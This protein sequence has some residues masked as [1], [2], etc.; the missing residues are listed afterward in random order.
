MS[1]TPRKA[2]FRMRLSAKEKEMV[3]NLRNNPL[4]HEE[5]SEL[6]RECLAKG[7]NI[8]TVKQV[9]YKDKHISINTNEKNHISYSDVREDMITAMEGYSPSYPKIKR[10]KKGKHLL[11]ID[12]ADLHI[13]KYSDPALT[14][15]EYNSDIAVKRALE[16]TKGLIQKASG[17]NID[18]ILFIIGNDVLNTDTI[19]KTTTKGTP[20]D[21][22]LHWFK[23]F[24]L[25]RE[26]YV[27][28][29]EMCMQVADVD[30]IH[31]PSNH[32]VMSGSFLADALA[33]WFR[34]SK[35]VEFFISPSYRKYYQYG[36]NMMEFEHGDK[37]K[38]QNLPLIMAQEQPV[39]W[40][41]TKYRYGYLHHVHHSD[42]TQF[43]SGKDYI[44]VNVTYLKSPSSADLWHSDQGYISTL[45][46]EGFVH[47]YEYGRVAH[48]T[49][50]F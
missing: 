32:D 6:E 13:N 24:Q 45:A 7:I 48:L 37:G 46:V 2:P 49:H 18:K 4:T 21:T 15:D 5:Q 30:V 1:D 29:I 33:C 35:N 26:V 27:K 3:L 50:Y 44:G 9:W 17:F 31:C 40:S 22:D 23:A 47:H 25:A 12:I 16:G 34:K 14:G 8:N 41:E 20:Q 42:K 38:M 36:K 28:C 43:K 11:V 19:T 10:G 39:M